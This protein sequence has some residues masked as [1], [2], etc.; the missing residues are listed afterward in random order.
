MYRSFLAAAALSLAGIA[1]AVNVDG[2]SCLRDNPWAPRTHAGTD[3]APAPDS[4]FFCEAGY[5]DGNVLTGIRIWR[6]DWAVWGLSF[7]WGELEWG[8]IY[9]TPNSNDKKT[10]RAPN[11]ELTWKS[12]DQV[13][14]CPTALLVPRIPDSCDVQAIRMK[15]NK[16][17]SGRDA[18]G[19]IEVTVND[20]VKMDEGSDH[21]DSDWLNIDSGAKKI[22]AVQVRPTRH[23]LYDEETH[24]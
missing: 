13:C 18:V 2:Q 15:H 4:H 12:S 23:S 10:P 1:Y 3:W 24:K 11:K 14:E 19:R 7:Q 22:V 17:K 5:T 8:K 16:G 21:T 20:E 9:G 6:G